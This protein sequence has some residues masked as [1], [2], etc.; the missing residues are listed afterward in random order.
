MINVLLAYGKCDLS[1]HY[2]S[3]KLSL[4]N[5]SKWTVG[6]RIEY[7]QYLLRFD[8]KRNRREMHEIEVLHK[9]GVNRYL[10]Y[11]QRRLENLQNDPSRY[12]KAALKLL[13]H[14]KSLRMLALANVEPNWYKER[15]FRRYYDALKQ[16]N[17]ICARPPET[18]RIWRTSIPKGDGSLRWINDPRIA[19]RMYLWM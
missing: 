6:K 16:L 1:K 15:D 19:M 5:I 3:M 8:I 7:H 2:I 11:Q 9:K 18:F 10:L 4:P 17:G 14:S 13:R 12:W